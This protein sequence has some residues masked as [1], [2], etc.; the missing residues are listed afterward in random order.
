[1]QPFQRV[2]RDAMAAMELRNALMAQPDSYYQ[3]VF[4]GRMPT[5]NEKLLF[6]EQKVRESASWQTFHNNLYV[7]V[8]EMTSPLIH[9]S[10]RRLDGRPCSNWS[11][12]QQ[13]KNELIGPEHEAVELFPAESRPINTSNEFH[14]WAHPSPAYRF[15]F[16]FAANRCVT[17]R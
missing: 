11:H 10:V 5:V 16:G 1:M 8:I 2:V 12:L 3:T 15:P 9:A 6:I 13:I 14:R 4:G 7:V 17:H